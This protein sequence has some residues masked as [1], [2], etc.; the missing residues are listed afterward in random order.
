MIDPVTAFVAAQTAVATIK[1]AMALGKDITSIIGEFGKFFDAKDVVQKAV[2][3]AGKKGQSDTSKALETVMQAEQLRQ[4]EDE[5]KHLLMYGYGQA[6]LWDQLL[7]ER[8]KIRQAKERDARELER[9]RKKIA[10]QRI[11]WAIGITIFV[12]VGITLVS[13]VVFIMSVI[14]SR[15]TAWIG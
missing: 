8:N 2:N 12:T 6:G 9:K 11:D 3:D 1:K 15:G 10:K 4:Y 7:L 13:L 14:N 5:L